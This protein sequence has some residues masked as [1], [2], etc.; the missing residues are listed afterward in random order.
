MLVEHMNDFLEKGHYFENLKMNIREVP[1]LGG[2]DL[3]LS[4]SKDLA[5]PL[6]LVYRDLE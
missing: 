1:V 5:S 4:A 2:G 6:S 3:A